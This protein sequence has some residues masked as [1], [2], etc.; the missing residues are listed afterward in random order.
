MKTVVISQPMLFP[1]VG[2]FEQIQ[3]ADSFVYYDDVQFSKGSFTNRVQL[4][5]VKGSEWMTIPL[6]KLTLGQNINE[7]EVSNQLD[8]RKKHLDQLCRCYDKSPYYS[9]M[10]EL[11]ES[12]YR[13]EEDSL[14]EIGILSMD[15]VCKYYGLYENKEFTRSS[16]LNIAGSSSQRVLDVVL[17]IGGDSYVTGH[18][19]K[20]YLDHQL[21]EENYVRVGYMDYELKPYSQLN[22][23][24]TP[25]VSILDLIA[26]MGRD[27]SG[28]IVSKTKYWK[29]FIK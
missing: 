10:M 19:A 11:V 22:G 29:D 4:K 13:I 26:N 14:C 6:N 18:G 28:Y 9:E 25:Y 3:L 17:S 21:F 8:W 23:E 15:A 12:I 1:W 27:G 24:F 5:G 20:K 2:M 16:A 7:V